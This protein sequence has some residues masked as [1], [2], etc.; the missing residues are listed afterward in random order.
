MKRL[1][2]IFVFMSMSVLTFAQSKNIHIVAD[3]NDFWN[4]WEVSLNGGV[5]TIYNI[6]N[7]KEGVDLNPYSWDS[8]TPV[9]D[10]YINKWMGTIFGMRLGF[11]SIGTK[12]YYKSLEKDNVEL[13][14]NSFSAHINA[15]LNITNLINGYDFNAFFYLS[16]FAGAGVMYS[17]RTEPKPESDNKIQ[18]IV[19]IGLLTTY[20]I[21]KNWAINL[22]FR[23][24]LLFGN[25]MHNELSPIT[26]AD[27][28]NQLSI[29]AGVTY[30]FANKF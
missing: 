15:L 12:Y 9:F 10:L 6:P 13:K 16:V 8:F 7:E 14:D 28:S 5:Q 30:K 26:T 4:N 23:D 17:K 18:L 27:F 11:S 3:N 25:N 22:E 19:P 21:N 20:N 1:F 2:I 24:L 29:S